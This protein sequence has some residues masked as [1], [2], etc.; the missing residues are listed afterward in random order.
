[1]LRKLLY[2]IFFSVALS[3]PADDAIKQRI[4]A[5]MRD[6][7]LLPTDVYLP[8]KDAKNLPCILIRSPAGCDQMNALSYIP[9]AKKGYAVAIQCTRS[10]LDAAGKT[11][12]YRSDGWHAQ[13]DGYDTV[14]WLAANPLTNG[15]IG[16]LGTSAQGITQLLM[17]P[18]APPSLKCQHISFAAPTLR[19]HAIFPNGKLLKNQVE[20]WLS[21]YARDP[22]I[23]SFVSNQQFFDPFW[24]EFDSLKVV[25]KVNAPAIIQGGW[26][27]IFIQGTL[28]AFVARQELGGEGARGKQKL[29]VGP[30]MHFWPMQT[31]LGDFEVPENGRQPPFDISP[32]AWF[33]HYLKDI[34]NG[35]EKLPPVTYYV[36]GPFDGSPSSGNIWRHAEKWPVPTEEKAFFLSENEKLVNAPSEIVQGV[37]T[38][39]HDPSNPVPTM[40]GHNLF[41]SSGPVDQRPI[42]DR[43]DVLIFTTEPLLEDM[44]ICGRLKALLYVSSDC[45]DTDFVL[46]LTDVYPDGRSILITDGIFRTGLM[47][48]PPLNSSSENQEI[49]VDLGSTCIVFAK[50]HRI[51]LSISGSNFPRYEI[52]RNIGLLGSHLHPNVVANNKIMYGESAPSKIVLPLF[53]SLK[54]F[55]HSQN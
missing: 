33:D 50:G 21:F 44:E 14:E 42:E 13:Q 23:F 12:P 43:S 9:L 55:Q 2:F 7:L 11:I 24:D 41:I 54:N 31:S 16:T 3:L 8:D 37:K 47:S 52:N 29:I 45:K 49:H 10:Y 46:R 53:P 19:D 34:P 28:D 25:D 1:M 27:D 22:G 40:G 17:A 18:A 51:R 6:G 32:L 36:M 38:F 39:I 26:F 35:V 4:F 30:W 48:A 15:K 20:A 5:P